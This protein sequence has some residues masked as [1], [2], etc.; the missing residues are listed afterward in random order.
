M[1]NS[2]TKKYKIIENKWEI[3]GS[4]NNNKQIIENT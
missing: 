2:F 4:F 3:N 1:Q